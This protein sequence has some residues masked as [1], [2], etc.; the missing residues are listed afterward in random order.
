MKALFITRD[1]VIKFTSMNGNIDTDKFIQYVSMA[2]DIYIQNYLGSKLFNKITN[3]IIA[4]DLSEPYT[5][6][7]N[8]YIK[9]MVIHWTMVL[10]LPF[11]AYNITNKGIYK[12]NA[13]SSDTASKNEIDML[14]ERERDLAE[15]YTK[16]FIDYMCFNQVD[17]PEYNTNSNDDMYPDKDT[18][19]AGWVL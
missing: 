10:Y 17:F 18:Y 15:H 13:E 9:P 5:S 12:H 3:D 16:R 8:N 11:A 6:L 19:F 14:V 4:D 1:D 7:L 2:Q